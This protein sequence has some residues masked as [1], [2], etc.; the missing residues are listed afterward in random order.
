MSLS[1]QASPGAFSIGADYAAA[2][3]D[4]L[5]DDPEEDDPEED[6][7]EEDDPEEDEVEDDEAEDDELVEDDVEGDDVA[8]DDE[9]VAGSV[10]LVS[11]LSDLSP[12]AVPFAFSALALP[13]RE[14]L[15]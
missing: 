4:D 11:D 8:D 15:R 9:A 13:L 10:F 3:P 7:P 6:D 1:A 12:V 5:D 2:L 14:S